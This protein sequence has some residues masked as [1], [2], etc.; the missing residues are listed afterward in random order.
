MHVKSKQLRLAGAL[1]AAAFVQA[2]NAEAGESCII[3]PGT[4]TTYASEAYNAVTPFDSVVAP[5]AT[6][7][8][9]AFS[10]FDSRFMTVDFAGFDEF[11][12]DEPKG[13]MIRF[14]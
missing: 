10:V 5:V 3:N 6:C 2:A 13:F 7:L 1:L 14:R 4:P 9:S 8:P 11:R 12:S